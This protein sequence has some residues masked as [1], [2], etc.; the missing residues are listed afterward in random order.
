M[1]SRGLARK[2]R[3]NQ[4]VPAH[5]FR[6]VKA[7]IDPLPSLPAHTG[8]KAKPGQCGHAV[9]TRPGQTGHCHPHFQLMQ[10][11]P[12]QAIA[13]R[14]FQFAQARAKIDQCQPASSSHRPEG[15]T[16][17]C[18]HASSSRRPGSEQI[19][20]RLNGPCRRAGRVCRCCSVLNLGS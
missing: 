18:H 13:Q 1:P 17:P 5:Q 16:R 11:R 9:Q 4:T 20:R 6:Q 8:Q 10:A 2:A 19:R 14:S 12:N 7:K 15:Q 3:P